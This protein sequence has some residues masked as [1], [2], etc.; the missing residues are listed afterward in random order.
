[1]NAPIGQLWNKTCSWLKVFSFTWEGNSFCGW[2]TQEDD[3]NVY[4]A[5]RLRL[6]SLNC[7]LAPCT[8]EYHQTPFV[9]GRGQG[10][11]WQRK[12]A[13]WPEETLHHHRPP[14][15]TTHQHQPAHH[16]GVALR[17][18]DGQGGAASPW[19]ETVADVLLLITP[20]FFKNVIVSFL[21]TTTRSLYRE[22]R[23]SPSNPTLTPRTGTSFVLMVQHS[24]SRESVS[25]FLHLIQQ[26][27]TKWTCTYRSLHCTAAKHRAIKRNGTCYYL[28]ITS[29]M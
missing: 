24:R 17:L 28:V 27:L 23:S 12:A 9:P 5:L 13:G 25:R 26:P 4:K 21:P 14:E 18:G 10:S 15:T 8:F 2:W 16:G 6:W 1:M 19:T 11:G 29:W 22:D 20:S 7:W 3:S